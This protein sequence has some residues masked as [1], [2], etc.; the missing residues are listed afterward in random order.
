MKA[1]CGLALFL[2]G[3]VCGSAQTEWKLV[4]GDE[5]NARTGTPPDATKWVYDLG[6]TGWGNNELERYTN[7]GD[8]IFQDGNGHLVIKAIKKATGYTSARIKTQGK[9]DFQYGQLEARIKLPKGQGIWPAFWMLGS[10]MEADGWPACG[11]IDVMENIGKEP[12]TVHSTIHGPEYFAGQ[13]LTTKYT[14]NGGAVLS[15]DFHVFAVEWKPGSLAFSVDQQTYAG[16][17]PAN[18]PAGAKWAFDHP[19]WILLN[20]AVGGDWPGPPDATTEFPQSM[21]VDWVRVYQ[22]E[23][24]AGGK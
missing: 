1:T 2:F 18:L 21:L 6:A 17:T 14:L 19:F 10:N 8:N 24:P 16:M 9:F 23:T 15:D 5:F 7:S 11:E 4:W 3:A 12:S 22:A 13:A 20:L